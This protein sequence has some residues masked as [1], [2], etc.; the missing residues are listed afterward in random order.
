MNSAAQQGS[1]VGFNPMSSGSIAATSSSGYTAEHSEDTDPDLT[2]QSSIPPVAYEFGSQL[3]QPRS[4]YPPPLSLTRLWNSRAPALASSSSLQ[5]MLDLP[6]GLENQMIQLPSFMSNPMQTSNSVYAASPGGSSKPYTPVDY[7]TFTGL[8]RPEPLSGPLQFANYASSNSFSGGQR[9]KVPHYGDTYQSP[10]LGSLYGF[11]GRGS[12]K[13]SAEQ[14]HEFPV[15]TALKQEQPDV[16]EMLK[17]ELAL[18]DQVN[19]TLNEKLAA[20]ES[21]RDQGHQDQDMSNRV[22]LPNNYHKLFKDLVCVLDE[23]TQELEDV[24]FKLEGI[25]V[26]LVMTNDTTITTHGSFDA[27]ELA[28]RIT[29]KLSVLQAENEALLKMVSYSNK[30]SL[31]VELGLLRNENKMLH[32][33]LQNIEEKRV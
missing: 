11:D 26:G 9:K 21:H 2:F 20:A 19:E 33:K 13:T 3:K 17:V 16:V 28:H 6:T 8:K 23:K 12:D 1:N 22:N 14:L 29:N 25:V 10:A 32:D 27:Q 5:S 18:K 30:Q 7:S 15:S 24:K 31:L 4:H